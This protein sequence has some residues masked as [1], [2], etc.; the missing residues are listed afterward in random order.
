MQNTQIEFAF[1]AL[2]SFNRDSNSDI[3]ALVIMNDDDLF[4]RNENDTHVHN[5]FLYHL[6]ERLRRC[7]KLM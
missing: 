6:I 4:E 3:Q 7:G 5:V 1:D 2:K